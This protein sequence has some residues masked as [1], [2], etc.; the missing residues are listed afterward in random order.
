MPKFQSPDR[1]PH[2]LI[3]SNDVVETKMAGPGMRYLEM[4]HALSEG[5]DVTLAVPSDSA[6][7][8]T[9]FRLVRYW[10]E[11]PGGLRVLVENSDVALVSG[12]MVEKFSFL[13]HTRT[14]LVID[15]YDPFIL[16]NLHYYTDEPPQE[17]EDL[18]RQAVD[19]TNRL[20]QI[21]DFFICGSERQ[22]DFWMGVL[23]ANR[24]INPRTFAQ[25]PS[26]RS[27]IDVVGIGFPS[28]EPSRRPMLR[29]I[30][31][32]F[33]AESRIVLWG[34]G[35][36]DWLD[37]ATL[38]RAWPGVL[39]R[40][41]EARLVFLGTR[42]PN[43]LVP[44]HK[45]AELTQALA[46]EIGEEGRTIFF[47]EWLP[48]EEREGL[49]CEADV[50]VVLHPQHVETRYSI[51]TR[52]L[53][54][55]WARLPVLVSDGD[56]T[57]DWVREYGVGQ[58]VPPCDADAVTEALCKMLERPKRAWAPAFEPLRD[59][60]LWT[61]VVEP[62]QRFCLHGSYASDR[63]TRGLPA[64]GQALPGLRRRLARARYIWRTEGLGAL[65]HRT[66]R[67]IRW[68]LATLS[69]FEGLL[70]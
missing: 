69:L 67:Y 3:V 59:A 63:E 64:R 49:L 30:H 14:R 41:P 28:R 65:L 60:F 29:D 54:Y 45:K 44:R 20:V 17:Q 24:R 34:G 23:V 6:I 25:D 1:L 46:K 56:V 7:E 57:S 13:Q 70:R 31:P 15:L 5:L 36:W 48:Y 68:R 18:N 40:H 51:R 43:P 10:E 26:L 21:G 42:H 33:P 38:V 47:Y 58:V 11:R 12:Y 16:E 35:I 27:L 37:P 2:L 9:A 61:R 66:W 52:V 32:A 55:L 19:V 62:L 50:G 4:A 8:A 22:R 39:A 53:D